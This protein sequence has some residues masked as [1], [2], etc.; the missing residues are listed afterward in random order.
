M[1]RLPLWA[2]ALPACIALGVLLGVWLRGRVPPA[3]LANVGAAAPKDS[4]ARVVAAPVAAPAAVQS[5]EAGAMDSA[6]LDPDTTGWGW[7]GGE[8]GSLSEPAEADTLPAAP[9]G[10]TV[11]EAEPPVAD[12]PPAA[13]RP[14]TAVRPS[15]P[16]PAQELG[17]AEGFSRALV[18]AARGGGRVSFYSAW[19]APSARMSL[20]GE[21]AAPEHCAGPVR[22]DYEQLAPGLGA[23]RGVGAVREAPAWSIALLVPRQ[24]CAAA[25][26]SWTGSRSPRGDEVAMFA[27][28]GGGDR[29]TGL[30]VSG[31]EAWIAWPARAVRARIRNGQAVE[32]WSATAGGG[33]S[34]RLLGVWEGEGVWVATGA[35]GRVLQVWRGRGR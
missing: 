34:I 14:P 23:M 13:P 32:E 31:D 27:P 29:P 15:G 8:Y 11:E 28:L 16:G 30:V 1:K 19:D 22:L 9:A 12:S 21:W 7:D 5:P 3:A 6:S 20:V 24:H 33:T 25:R 18:G 4:S 10:P 2:W 17:R 35:G 26:A